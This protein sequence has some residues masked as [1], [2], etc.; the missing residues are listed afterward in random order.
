MSIVIG[1]DEAGRG[2]LV[3]NVVAA[4]V[5]LPF[6]FYLPKLTDSKKLS[7]KK[8]NELYILITEQCQWSIGVATPIEIDDINILQATMTAMSRAVHGL[9]VKYDEVIVDGNKCPELLNCTAIIK[10]DLTE[11]A[12][13]AASII[14]KVTRDREMYALDS[15]FPEYFF[16]K[17]KGYGTKLHLEMLNKHGPLLQHHRKSFA[18]IRRLLKEI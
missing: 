17:H 16:A 3:G 18:P 1:V 5:I 12:I 2:P 6:D 15:K 7:E 4:A 13:S 10:G 8:R 14:A 9:G 11:P